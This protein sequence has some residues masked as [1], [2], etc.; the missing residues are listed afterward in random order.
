MLETTT[1]L[2]SNTN[3]LLWTL[4]CIF[5]LL[6]FTPAAWSASSPPFGN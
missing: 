2:W 1:F 6:R 3:P 4:F 5:T